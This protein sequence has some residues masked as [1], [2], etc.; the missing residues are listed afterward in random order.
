[1]PPSFSSTSLQGG[2]RRFHHV[3]RLGDGQ[4]DAVVDGAEERQRAVGMHLLDR[5]AVIFAA[6]LHHHRMR[7]EA[8]RRQVLRDDA[9]RSGIFLRGVGGVEFAHDAVIGIGRGHHQLLVGGDEIVGLEDVERNFRGDQHDDGAVGGDLA[10]RDQP[11]RLE[12]QIVAGRAADQRNVVQPPMDGRGHRFLGIGQAV[13]EAEREGAVGQWQL[14]MR[15]RSRRRKRL[16]FTG[17]PVHARRGEV[18][19]H[20]ADRENDAE[21]SSKASIW[22]SSR[23]C[24]VISPAVEQPA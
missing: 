9:D 7:G 19:D 1:M 4:H 23:P 18:V 5:A 14:P 3:L 10:V 22:P 2:A 12:F 6:D 8:E 24:G 17:D 20:G 16:D 11:G 21:G 15:P 13:D